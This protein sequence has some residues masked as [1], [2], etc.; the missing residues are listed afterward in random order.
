MIKSHNYILFFSMT[1]YIKQEHITGLNTPILT[2]RIMLIFEIISWEIIKKP[3]FS[4]K[5]YFQ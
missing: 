3:Y 4:M 2:G 1:V 5:H